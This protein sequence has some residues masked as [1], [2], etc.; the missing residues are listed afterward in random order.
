MVK[1]IVRAAALKTL[2]GEGA[3]G[4]ASKRNR[5]SYSTRYEIIKR[6]R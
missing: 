5:K 6:C 2:L 4:L 3:G 1:E